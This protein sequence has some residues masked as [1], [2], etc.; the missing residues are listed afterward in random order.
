PPPRAPWVGG[1]RK[2]GAGLAGDGD[3][4]PMDRPRFS[5]ILPLGGTVLGSSRV[6]PMSR[7]GGREEVLAN[8]QR[9]RL[10]ALVAIGGDDTLGVAAWLAEQRAPVVGVPKT[11]DN[12]LSI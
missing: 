10:D 3:M 5:G 1:V 8:L 9:A 4:A 7:E 11:M 2:G 6:N 12:D